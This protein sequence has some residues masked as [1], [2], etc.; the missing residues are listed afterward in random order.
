MV[1]ESPMENHTSAEGP[2]PLILEILQGSD[3][4]QQLPV[5][6][7]NLSARGVILACDQVPGDFDPDGLGERDAIVHLPRGEIREIR[8]SLLW[9]RPQGE[10]E[11]GMVFGIELTNPNMRVR[12]ALE[13]QLTAY[14]VDI[15]NL[16][17]HWDAVHDDYEGFASDRPMEQPDQPEVPLPPKPAVMESEAAPDPEETRASDHTIYWVG[18]AA[19]AAGLAVYYLAPEFYRLFGAILAVYGS[20]AIVGKGVWSLVKKIPRSQVQT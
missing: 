19:V 12:R 6:I 8:G 15:K 1:R 2:L 20:L 4:P 16:W 13:E 7:R 3:P 18:L 9:T 11:A 17:D 10:V 5:R 14:P